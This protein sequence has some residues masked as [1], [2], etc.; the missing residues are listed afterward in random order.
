MG[1]SGAAVETDDFSSSVEVY[2]TTSKKEQRSSIL[3]EHGTIPSR[4]KNRMM[5]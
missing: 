5:D 4:K 3:L 2:T 1:G